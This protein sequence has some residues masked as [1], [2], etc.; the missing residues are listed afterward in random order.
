MQRL[1]APSMRVAPQ[2]P[3]Q[4]LQDRGAA[5]TAGSRVRSGIGRVF[6]PSDDSSYIFCSGPS[7]PALVIDRFHGG[8][9]RVVLASE[10]DSLI[11]PP[12][13]RAKSIVVESVVGLI[14]FPDDRWLVVVT[15][16]QS[17]SVTTESGASSAVYIKAVVMLPLKPTSAGGPGGTDGGASVGDV[18][19]PPDSTISGSELSA[20]TIGAKY[21]MY[22]KELLEAGDFFLAHEDR[23]ALTHTLQRR[24]ARGPGA[25]SPSLDDA[26]ERFVWNRVALEPLAE[27][28]AGVWLT[29]IMQ[30]A[31]HTERV[32]LPDGSV[33]TSSLISR[34]SAEH[35]GTRLKTRGLNDDGAAANCVET[36]QILHLQAKRSA[37][38]AFVQIRGSAPIFWE[39]RGKTVN[40]RPRVSRVLQLTT[41]AFKEH[42]DALTATYGSPLLLSLLD[43]KGDEGELCAA[44]ADCVKALSQPPLESAP[45]LTTF[46]FHAAAKASG[47]ADACRS[48]LQKL[49]SEHQ[50][51]YASHGYFAARAGVAQPAGTQ[52]G[53]VRTN[54][55]DC[56][57]RTNMAQT[58][59]ALQSATH[60]MRALL[61]ACDVDERLASGGEWE[62]LVQAALHKMWME[63]G[64]AISLQY[65]GTANLSKGSSIT[66]G[67]TKKSLIER[68]SG[69][70]EKV[71]GPGDRSHVHASCVPCTP[72]GG[73]D[74]APPMTTAH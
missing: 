68:A 36:E 13:E 35:A 53:V 30:A 32:A 52:K 56:L 38:T 22:V 4:P 6:A 9:A 8:A 31:I 17:C 60:Q 40:P 45:R 70:V 62:P 66:G 44:L 74:L 48:L 43:Q 2:L 69:L 50:D 51:F 37:V 11:G 41:P 47:R 20:A 49:A 7:A 59:L 55:L 61:A 67:E 14:N 58:M 18:W 65:T 29:P 46:D 1:A 19:E 16:V 25:A 57:N 28:G 34:R 5:T 10:I 27:A 42:V 26:D 23:A 3:P 72:D 15:D 54:C 63:T 64:D 71:R 21:R 33:L 24:A 12:G 39:Q 73:C